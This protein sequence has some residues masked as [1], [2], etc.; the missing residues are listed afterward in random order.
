MSV[1]S[2]QTTENAPSL[3]MCMHPKKTVSKKQTYTICCLLRLLFGVHDD[4]RQLTPISV[5]VLL[6]CL[7]LLIES[8]LYLRIMKTYSTLFCCYLVLL[9]SWSLRAAAQ[10]AGAP[11]DEAVPIQR[12]PIGIVHDASQDCDYV[13]YDRFVSFVVNFG[14]N[15]STSRHQR[16]KNFP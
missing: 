14:P 13:I 9:A 10:G 4:P 15:V 16:A 6:W 2:N 7:S 1:T 8:R 3:R 5:V 11:I 12:Q